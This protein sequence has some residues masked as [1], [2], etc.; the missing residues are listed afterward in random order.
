MW[1]GEHEIILSGNN[2]KVKELI[3]LRQKAKER[4]EKKQFVG[5]GLR[6]FVDTPPSRLCSVYA[7]ESFLHGCDLRTENKLKELDPGKL[8]IL[9]EHVMKKAAGTESPQG[10]LFTASVAEYEERDLFSGKEE[11]F[12]LYLEDIQD[13][14]NLGTIFRTAE[15]AGVSGIVMSRGTVDIYNPK[16]VRATMSAIYRIPFLYRED[17]RADIRKKQQQGIRFFAADLAGK[18]AYDEADY[19]GPCG[20]LIGNEGNGLQRE[21]AEMADERVLIPMKGGIES[22]NASMAA[23]I[24]M[25]EVFRQRRKAF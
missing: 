18:Q 6:L 5:E 9:E 19:T 12:L 21:T 3:Q 16:T 17:L 8:V 20:L 10:I 1:W 15:A 14:G 24:L 2:L 13:P 25:Y 11:P 23:G 22:L 7:T 4:R